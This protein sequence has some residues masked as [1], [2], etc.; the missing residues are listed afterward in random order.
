M[1]GG[2]LIFGPWRWFLV[3]LILYVAVT[4]VIVLRAVSDPSDNGHVLLYHVGYGV[5]LAVGMYR[6][7]KKKRRLESRRD[8]VPDD[9]MQF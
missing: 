6:D 7:Y 5:F 4:L 2:G 8:S 1:R 3:A 9:R